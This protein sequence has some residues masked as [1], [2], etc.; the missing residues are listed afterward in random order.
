MVTPSPPL[1]CCCRQAL[2][3]LNTEEV[4]AAIHAPPLDALPR[5]APCSDVLHY[6]H[7]AG[8]MIPVHR[9]NLDHGAPRLI[10]GAG[11]GD[12]ESR[13]HPAYFSITRRRK[14]PWISDG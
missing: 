8:S 13:I 9:H 4:R 3:W 6:Q 1:P 12:L 2:V 5:W 11:G 10:H 14:D 7:D